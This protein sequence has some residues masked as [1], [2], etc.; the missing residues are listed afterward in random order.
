MSNNSSYNQ[1]IRV[2]EIQIIEFIPHI[3][4]NAWANTLLLVIEVPLYFVLSFLYLSH[5]LIF[6]NMYWD[7]C[8][9]IISWYIYIYK[10]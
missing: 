4:W 6:R 1:D 8:K 9:N 3:Y 7:I 5:L 2:S 10:L